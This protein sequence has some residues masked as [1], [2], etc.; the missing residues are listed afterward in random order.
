MQ[1]VIE[2]LEGEREREP[3]VPPG[4]KVKVGVYSGFATEGRHKPQVHATPGRHGWSQRDASP[5]GHPN[6]IRTR[7]SPASAWDHLGGLSARS[8]GPPQRRRVPRTTLFVDSRPGARVR[9]DSPSLRA[10]RDPSTNDP[11]CPARLPARAAAH[12]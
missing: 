8:M 4:R 7:V 9:V 10:R 1:S 2:Q 11:E 3:H 6:G 12:R 5:H